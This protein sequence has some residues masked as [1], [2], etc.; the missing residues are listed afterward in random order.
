LVTFIAGSPSS[1]GSAAIA[2]RPVAFNQQINALVPHEGD[3]Q[4]ATLIHIQRDSIE[5]SARQ[6]DEVFLSSQERAF[7]ETL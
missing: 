4:R 6:F 1:I 2:D 7:Q 5:N 3:A